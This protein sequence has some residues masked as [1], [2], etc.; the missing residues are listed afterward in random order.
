MTELL[1]DAAGW[2][3][4]LLIL[5]AYLLLTL[6]RVDSGSRLYQWMNVLGA[7]GFIVN[8]IWNHAYPSAVLN[9]VWAAIG[10]YSLSRPASGKSA[11]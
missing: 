6:R 5:G 10:V 8:C 3:A 2:L 11:T 9:V 7:A 1:V 4:M